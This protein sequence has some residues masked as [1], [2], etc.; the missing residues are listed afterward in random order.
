MSSPASPLALAQQLELH[1]DTPP[2]PP[3][4]PPSPLPGTATSSGGSDPSLGPSTKAKPVKQYVNLC[5]VLLEPRADRLFEPGYVPKAS[6]GPGRGTTKPRRVVV[7][8]DKVKVLDITIA[9]PVPANCRPRDTF[10]IRTPNGPIKVTV[11]DGKKPG[12]TIHLTLKPNPS[13]KRRFGLKA[14]VILI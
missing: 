10:H 2:P 14:R 3:P 13:P 5:N 11:P 8:S 9:V 4:P 1:S 7:K 12:D 6:T